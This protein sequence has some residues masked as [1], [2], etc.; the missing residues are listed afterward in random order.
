MDSKNL[1]GIQHIVLGGGGAKRTK[2]TEGGKGGRVVLR[3]Q[4]SGKRRNPQ[5]AQAPISLVK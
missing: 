5:F 4:E 2:E 3:P 1:L